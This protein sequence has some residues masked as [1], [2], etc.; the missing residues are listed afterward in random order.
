M[1]F[2]LILAGSAS[3]QQFVAPGFQ[4]FG[5]EAKLGQTT[6]TSVFQDSTGLMWVATYAGIQKFNGQE[7]QKAGATKLVHEK[8]ENVVRTI[9][10]HQHRIYFLSDKEVYYYDYQQRKLDV[11]CTLNSVSS[12]VLLKVGAKGF[13]IFRFVTGKIYFIPF[14]TG[15]LQEISPK[16]SLYDVD[17]LVPLKKRVFAASNGGLLSITAQKGT[18]TK[19]DTL[20]KEKRLQ[21]VPVGD[22]SVYFATENQAG[23]IDE[24]NKVLAQDG[25]LFP[26]I[27]AYTFQN[28]QLITFSHGYIDVYTCHSNGAPEKIRSLKMPDEFADLH[29]SSLY[30]DKSGN[31]WMTI[32]GKGLLRINRNC[33]VFNQTVSNA[34]SGKFVR[35][36]Q[37]I[38]DTSYFGVVGEG[39]YRYAGAALSFIDATKN[40]PETKCIQA[41]ERGILLGTNNGLFIINRKGL[42]TEVQTG[43]LGKQ[44][45]T[46]LPVAQ[47]EWLMA[48]SYGSAIISGHFSS[49]TFTTDTLLK[50]SDGL[51]F[52]APVGNNK[53]LL[54]LTKGGVQLLQRS[55]K[56]NKYRLR[57][58]TAFD[59]LLINMAIARNDTIWAAT[60]TGILVLDSALNQLPETA[61]Y[62]ALNTQ[63][64]YALQ[65][66]NRQ[67]LWIS[68]NTG[69][70]CVGHRTLYYTVHQ[71]LQSNEFN[72]RCVVKIRGGTLIFGGVEG[73][74]LFKPAQ[75]SVDTFCPAPYIDYLSNAGKHLALPQ[76]A[77][78][79]LSE[80]AVLLHMKLGM[81]NLTES[82]GNTYFVALANNSDTA[83]HWVNIG[84]NSNYYLQGLAA[85]SYTVFVRAKNSEKHN[86]PVARLFQLDV[87]PLFYKQWWFLSS[88]I[89]VVLFFVFYTLYRVNKHK[90][91]LQQQRLKRQQ[92]ID[93]MRQKIADDMHDDLGAGLT[94]LTLMIENMG[95]ANNNVENVAKTAAFARNLIETLRNVIWSNNPVNE[96]LS[97]LIA[98]LNEY[99]AGA[100]HDAHI[101]YQTVENIA[102]PHKKLNLLQRQSILLIIKEAANNVLKH[103][104]ATKVELVVNEANELLEIMLKDNGRGFDAGQNTRGN[105]MGSMKRRAKEIAGKLAIES[106][107]NEYTQ[108]KLTV[109][110]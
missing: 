36:M 51:R 83:K 40:L 42:P 54:A 64:C 27:D 48:G 23:I 91:Q 77:V 39:V 93:Q 69:L 38:N 97:E 30:Y 94:R 32:E 85:G 13:Y 63:F 65:F 82:A 22:N 70:F 37:I 15:A 14:E 26:N 18:I 9:F 84:N 81:N 60:S 104:V 107:P 87:S 79:K 45:N 5:A 86:S 2:C 98:E 4:L 66:D 58:Y 35:C 55:H 90:Y 102:N 34:L 67:K 47:N 52:L 106:K 100:M 73:V 78:L 71:G 105:G 61:K 95:Y 56:N 53:W 29:K 72:S 101:S 89:F 11:F 109:K 33:F 17:L 108:V 10:Q 57:N 103:A 68:T 99:I 43:L 59:S 74:N 1:P 62:K 50:T 12:F 44:Y 20:L 80:S 41:C 24:S 8:Y 76:K 28:N 3:A 7:F 75:L 31:L 25:T 49:A 6:I 16:I 92:E 46:V 19:I 96:N 110:L 21:L 88:L